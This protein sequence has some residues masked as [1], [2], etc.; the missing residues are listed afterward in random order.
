M[1]LVKG[2]GS[3]SSNYISHQADELLSG[4]EQSNEVNTC[5]SFMG[6]SHLTSSKDQSD[7]EVEIQRI[8]EYWQKKLLSLTDH[9]SYIKE[10]L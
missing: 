5:G 2:D 8:I 9:V 7:K 3:C 6:D 1:Y 4:K 10:H